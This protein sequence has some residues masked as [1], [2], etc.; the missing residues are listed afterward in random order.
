MELTISPASSRVFCDAGWYYLSGD[1]D[2]RHDFRAALLHEVEGGDLASEEK[3]WVLDALITDGLVSRDP[4][5]RHYL[6]EW[7]RR[8]LA[9]GPELPTLLGS[10]GAVLVEFDRYEEGKALLA[11]LATAS[12]AES[13]D[14]FM[15]RAFLALAERALENAAAAQELAN[16]ARTAAEAIQKAPHVMAMLARLDSEIPPAKLQ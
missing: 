16:A 11:P 4:A 3:M 2:A 13:L 7:S 8:A 9:L 1:T 5:V 14:S 12:Q 10:R 6:D 15:S